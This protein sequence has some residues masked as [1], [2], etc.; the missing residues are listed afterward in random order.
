MQEPT[1]EEWL[2][3][4]DRFEE[5]WNFPNCCGAIDGKHIRIEAPWNSG[6]VFF[7]YKSY[8]SIVLQAVVDAEGKF[9][10]IDV[11]EAG[12]NSD[13]GVFLSSS[14]GEMFNNMKL[15][16]PKPR[17]LYDDKPILFPYVFVGDEAYALHK[18]MMKPFAKAS[19]TRERRIYNYRHSR[20]RRIVECAFGMMAKKF[21]VFELAMLVHPDV[22]KKVVLACCVLHNIIRVKEGHLHE[23][24]DEI[25]NIS[26]DC[27]T[28]VEAVRA[29]AAKAA[30]KVRDN[31][32]E[33][34]NSPT[35]SVPWQEQM[36][37]V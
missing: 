28:E 18:N 1:T 9:V 25:I 13:G 16:L 17:K 8:N 6:S 32:L 5:L 33:Y 11:G 30:Y 15:K 20:A 26:E 29:R 19:L 7:N 22:S 14:F 3:I 23:V 34:F 27:D 24:Y 35:G 31:F 36:A 37:F 10:T 21:R 2:R 4:A 12:K